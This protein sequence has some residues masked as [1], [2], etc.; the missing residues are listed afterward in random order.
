MNNAVGNVAADV[1]Q[2]N[3]GELYVSDYAETWLGI[4]DSLSNNRHVKGA[5]FVDMMHMAA[6]QSN[7]SN[8]AKYCCITWS[9]ATKNNTD[10]LPEESA[11][12]YP[13]LK[14]WITDFGDTSNLITPQSEQEEDGETIIIPA[15]SVWYNGNLISTSPVMEANE[16][17]QN[18]P[19]DGWV[20]PLQNVNRESWDAP[21]GTSLQQ[22]IDKNQ[23]NHINGLEGLI[24]TSALH[25]VGPR[26]W[27]SGMTGSEDGVGINTKTY[28]QNEEVDRHFMHLSFFAPG[29]DLRGK[30]WSNLAQEL[31]DSLLYGEGSW[32]N[33]LQGIWGG[34]VFTGKT[35]SETFGGGHSHL[36]MEGNYNIGINEVLTE[37][38]G[39]G[40]G[41][42]YDT[43]YR[44]LYERQWDPTFNISGDTLN[45]RRDF[46]RKI[47]AGSRF[48]FHRTDTPESTLAPIIDN[49]IYTIKSVQIKKLYNHTS[50]R[51]P[52]NR[53][54]AYPFSGAPGYSNI[55]NEHFSYQ[56]VE[57]VALR[58][59]SNV[60]SLGISNVGAVGGD[61]NFSYQ[62]NYPLTEDLKRKIEDFG[63]AH[64][65]RL[66]YIIELDKNPADSNSNMGN[67]LAVDDL[68]N[69][70]FANSNYTN[71]EFLDPVKDILL[72]DLSKFPA[73]W[74]VDPKKKEVDLDIYYEAS[75]S[76][77]VKLNNRT[78]DLFAPVGCKVE[79]LNTATIGSSIVE[80]WDDL[81][82]T[83]YPG[84]PK[85]DG[86]GIEI[87]YTGMSFKFTR[88]D[89][90]YTIAEASGQVL[91]GI[92]TAPSD[93]I[94]LKK[95][96]FNFREDIGGV[97]SSG[98]N[99]Y[100]CF[101]FGNGIESNRIKDDFNEPFITNGVKAS[102]TI[103]ERY[104]EERRKSGL[105]YSGIYNSNSGVNDLN[106]FIMAEKITKDLN[107]TYGSI[108]KLFQRRI[109][110]I[111]F[112]EDRVI[113]IVS[114]KDTL[115]NA[116]GNSQL[117][118]SDRVLGDANPF[119]GDFGIS[120]NPESFAAE[121]Y[122]AYFTDKQRGTVL[123]LS[124]DGLTPISNAGMKDWFRDY[125]P[126]YHALIG[127][128]DSYKEHYNITLT[129]NPGFYE[130]LVIDS[131]FDT[132]P[133]DGIDLEEGTFNIIQ[134]Q[135]PTGVSLQ[136]LWENPF[137]PVL[138][139]QNTSNV[140]NWQPFT[141]DDYDFMG[142]AQICHHAAIDYGELQPYVADFS[143][144]S[145][146]PPPPGPF[147]PALFAM[148]SDLT[149]LGWWYD[150]R[151]SQPNTAMTGNGHIFGPN[152]ADDMDLQVT[153]KITRMIIDPIGGQ[154]VINEGNPL[155][156][157]FQHPP[158]YNGVP[159]NDFFD[160]PNDGNNQTYN[161]TVEKR[162]GTPTG[163]FNGFPDGGYYNTGMVNVYHNSEQS[164]V[165]TRNYKYDG[166]DG[167]GILFDRAR[168]GSYVEFSQ[169]G[170]GA[171][172]TNLFDTYNAATGSNVSHKAWFNGEELHVQV[173][174]ML[175][176]TAEDNLGG[177]A[178][179]THGW[180][181]IAPQIQLIDGV[182]GSPINS[183]KFCTTLTAYNT[184]SMTT[185]VE[186][187]Y[188]KWQTLPGDLL[189]G[190]E[191]EG[192]GGGTASE[193]YEA[194]TI[195]FSTSVDYRNVNYPLN[196][197]GT[198]TTNFP[199]T[200]AILSL[201]GTQAFYADM[202]AMKKAM[203]GVS[204]KFR[205]PLQQNADGTP[206]VAGDDI[207]P[208]QVVGDLK[209][210]ISETSSPYTGTDQDFY[211]LLAPYAGTNVDPRWNQ[212]PDFPATRPIWQIEKLLCKKGLGVTDGS[213]SG[214]P[215]P[216]PGT[217]A[218]VDAVP[219]FDV[220]A[221]TEVIHAGE[222]G[223]ELGG[224][225][226]NNWTFKKD[227]SPGQIYNGI[228]YSEQH[229]MVGFGPNYTPAIEQMGLLQ[230]DDPTLDPVDPIYYMVPRDWGFGSANNGGLDQGGNLLTYTAL[231]NGLSGTF[232]NLSPW[233]SN[234]GH[235]GRPGYEF[236]RVTASSNSY[237][238][239][240]V[241]WQNA[242]THIK[243]FPG[244]KDHQIMSHDGL[245]GVNAW[246]NGDWYLV[247]IEWD[248]SYGVG[249][250]GGNGTPGNGSI[251]VV[252]VT[253]TN[254]PS[255]LDG[256]PV[257][258]IN[259]V[260]D[261]GQNLTMSDGTTHTQLIRLK[262][263]QRFRY[264]T[265]E[266]VL[267][268]IFKIPP[269]A[270]CL[271]GGVFAGIDSIDILF[272]DFTNAGIRVE[273]II[274]K[275]L[276]GNYIWDNWLTTNGNADDW[277]D[278]GGTYA[279]VDIQPLAN[280][281]HAFDVQYLYYYNSSLCWEIENT[282]PGNS[283]WQTAAD[284]YDWTQLL[285]PSPWI[286]PSEW[287]L[288]FTVNDN[289]Y[290][291]NPFIGGLRG[292]VTTSNPAALALAGATEGH[293][294]VYF[295]GI[296]QVGHYKIRFNFDGTA[297]IINWTFERANLGSTTFATHGNGTLSTTSASFPASGLPNYLS[298]N[299]LTDRIKFYPEEIFTDHEY[300]ISNIVLTDNT[301]I[302]IG[303]GGSGGWNFN[304]FDPSLY[305]YIYWDYQNL[306]LTFLACPVAVEDDDT[307][308]QEFIS[309]SQPIDATI[310]RY[311]K[312]KISFTHGITD[313]S[314]A[315]LS[316]YY[317]NS[318]GYGFKISNID[319]N[320]PGY[321]PIDPLT[322]LV[323]YAN[324]PS[325]APFELIVTIGDPDYIDYPPT[326]M[327][328]YSIGPSSWSSINQ[329]DPAFNPDLKNSFV[330][331][332]EGS[333]DDND[334]L[335]GYIDNL[336][337][338]RVFDAADVPDRTVSFTES[339][340]GWTSF[341]GF[342]PD[343]GV[344]ISKN[345]FTLSD[346]ML[347]QHYVPLVDG[348]NG[349]IDNNGQ[350][351]EYTL[352]DANNYNQFYNNIDGYSSITAILNQEPSM[353]KMF[354]TINYEGT[355]A[356]IIEPTVASEVTLNN[357]AAWKAQDD[358]LGW[359]CS[360]IITDLD[361]G[362]VAEFIEKEG[363]WFNYIKG[364]A[365]DGLDTSLF[366]AQG[367]GIIDNIINLSAEPESSPIARTENN[368]EVVEDIENTEVTNRRRVIPR[369]PL[370]GGGGGGGY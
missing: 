63:A 195:Y 209:I 199:N 151:F 225:Y 233:T 123:R 315:T 115:Y 292:F 112:C 244:N 355:Q 219:P 350:F 237:S 370:G 262:Q 281:V 257:D 296:D 121:S 206:L 25:S 167:G 28:S 126:E 326:P 71:I 93:P 29:R 228:G 99:W 53:F 40:V 327:T 60:N 186:D 146:P 119:S 319:N 19:I 277:I 118:A 193:P 188:I 341:K 67:P 293:E 76:I 243:T 86:G 328:G 117:I 232:A 16:S 31:T 273:K 150:P 33:S 104:K 168:A 297:S 279:T 135:G 111:A 333:L 365:T 72:S 278:N 204:Y 290:S 261:Y 322:G 344:S 49:E 26:R 180:N 52:Y 346:G 35:Q 242:Y 177:T 276:T 207:E 134:N 87:D 23:Q 285:N 69:A 217:G 316:I 165:I 349:Y 10:E 143:G 191:I 190:S 266:T 160:W 321:I 241:E 288:S 78:N 89:G 212:Q 105:I 100:N 354:N 294:G 45:N 331:Q 251:Y 302:F 220:P 255:Q 359:Q 203:I 90:S 61:P 51:I 337:M 182:T 88:E 223:F 305:N 148:A 287:E 336:V 314:T 268:G 205:D 83:L 163:G 82:V 360:Q 364:L 62:T 145:P 3:S 282:P 125:L 139:W 169:I 335:F 107:P 55:E 32:M 174:L 358:I 340:N 247:D 43:E 231:V 284:L 200:N 210:R 309:V 239:N 106:Q 176:K 235:L 274:C 234:A 144:P 301:P 254:A 20:G 214:P 267:R 120:K 137:H 202:S 136:Y 95:T 84:L 320:T 226:G 154:N 21:V 348:E 140:F 184:N 7:A 74:E 330:I 159:V 142:S 114:N 85:D 4:Q 179:N 141:Q 368:I 79:V 5:F 230:N 147:V 265:T 157:L 101:S 310:N 325:V 113:S 66:C 183:N 238:Y 324:Y 92:V 351:Q 17:Y 129:N 229:T 138:E 345:Y 303:G 270:N 175:F 213:Q 132:G 245:T 318:L 185:G 189:L 166:G 269:N 192:W 170:D 13:P 181:Y 362:S 275:K 70:D 283:N 289:A 258:L 361:D 250:N 263:A 9:G 152:A 178:T 194:N 38:P 312:Y 329:L 133:I 317:Y 252:G 172:S 46:I 155:P 367:V 221:W 94:P 369:R 353:V 36:A 11:W 131:Y 161:P 300:A 280:P 224:G 357:V 56:S 6:G 73:I 44:M 272:H 15:E 298:S 162:L 124:K 109:S 256:I 57:E 80:S 271:T 253:G 216:T 158:G 37:P 2:A 110:L 14:T 108:Q 338:L 39:P 352:K 1:N 68:M 215:P 323:D 42:G 24:T 149:D 18:L 218:E 122:R 164:S 306:H 30:S 75:N 12:S 153:S 295:E 236:N 156:A 81:T 47:H 58:W 363:K 77:P 311:E 291:N 91:D 130:N 48:R 208:V 173:E 102:T 366:S 34:G 127:T 356:Y 59:L 96:T 211:T 171:G 342:I 97:I 22:I 259:G 299:D 249:S 65:R 307:V 8:H 246:K 54:T 201:T 304:G 347:Y 198:S 240:T 27:F 98:L 103:Q 334:V 227:N 332:V 286:S 187:P 308:F 116:D 64:N 264:G 50:W 248:Q 339:V 196:G 343:N 222:F 313:N 260:G 128:Y 197:S 41:Y